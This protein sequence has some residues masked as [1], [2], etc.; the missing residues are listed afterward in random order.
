MAAESG[1]FFL[2]AF[3]VG[4][5]A[6]IVIAAIGALTIM[7][8]IERLWTLKSLSVDKNDFN[9]HLFGM[10]LRGDIRQAITYCDSKPAPLTNTLKTGLIQ[11]L[12]QRPDEEIQ[13][14]M[15]ASVLRETPR[16]EGWA[17]FLAV[18]GNLSTLAGLV[19]TIL[20]MIKSFQ[21][22]SRAGAAEKAALLSEGISEA[23][24]CTAFGLMV[25]IIGILFYGYFQVRI[26]RLINDMQESSMS[27]LNLVVANRDKVKE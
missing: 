7:L 5:P 20:G 24:H 6:M 12:N 13:V 18:F 3:K 2:T 16:I 8:V 10:I 27:M 23:L 4:G 26:S 17:A 22:V 21:G 11:V 14:A 15:D 9:E 19:G 1:N 25:A